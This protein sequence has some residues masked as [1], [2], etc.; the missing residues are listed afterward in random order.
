MHVDAVNISCWHHSHTAIVPTPTPGLT[1][2]LTGRSG[3]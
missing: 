1:L 2:K 3:G